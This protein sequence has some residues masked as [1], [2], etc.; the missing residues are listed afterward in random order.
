MKTKQRSNQSRISRAS[1]LITLTTIILFS[2]QTGLAQQWCTNGT[3]IYNCNSGNVGIGTTAPAVRLDLLSNNVPYGGQLRLAA[4]DYAQITFY[5]S[6]NL[7]LNEAGRKGTIYYDMFTSQFVISNSNGGSLLLNPVGGSTGIGTFS[8]AYKLD[9]RSTSDI[10]GR[11]SS[12]AAANS[13]VLIDA[14]NGF[15]SNLTLQHAGTSK[16]YLGNRAANNRFSFIESTGSVEVFSILQNGRVGIGTTTPSTTLHVIGDITVSG[17]INAKYQDVAEWVPTSQKLLPGTVVVVD[18]ERG[19]DVV[20]S[21]QAYDTK[22]AGVISTQPGL[23]LGESGA[24]KV[25]V[26]TTGRVRVKVD[27]T[28]GPIEI[29]DLLVT[30][31]REG[32]AMKS[33]PVQL[34]GSRI[35]RPGTLIGKALEPLAKGTGEI[36]VLLSLQ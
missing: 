35:H 28:D 18:A 12:T 14:P 33:I 13:Q 3:D 21:S 31:S 4:P 19:S 34:R 15:N 23:A 26:A 8:P 29:G 32:L 10:I 1:L 16:W 22:V 36:L 24:D 17:N 6:N 20:A 27:A 5:N 11:F 25:L 30:S 2:A 7:T 9:V